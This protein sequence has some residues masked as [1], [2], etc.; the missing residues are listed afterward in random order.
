VAFYKK[1]IPMELHYLRLLRRW[2]WLFALA[3]IIASVSAFLIVRGQPTVYEAST[4]MIVGSAIDSPNPDLNT[5]RASG[6]LLQTYAEL[7]T[8]RPFLQAII[9]ELDLDVS[10]ND[11]MEMLT[12]TANEETQILT[13][14]AT[15]RDPETAVAVA[16][17]VANRLVAVSPSG[18]GEATDLTEEMLAQAAKLEQDV[19]AIEAQ[20]EELQAQLDV[21][22]DIDRQRLLLDQIAEE[23]NRLADTNRTLAQLYDT[24]LQPVTNKVTIIEPAVEAVPSDPQTMLIVLV[25]GLTGLILSLSAVFAME[26]FS[27]TIETADDLAQMDV[28]V[29]GTI[30][31]DPLLSAQR[32]QL[33]ARELPKS[34][35][36]EMYR[37][38]GT[39]VLVLAESDNSQSILL[40]STR[41]EDISGLAANLAVVL[42]QA[43][44]RVILVDADFHHSSVGNAF[45]A[46]SGL[47]LTEALSGPSDRIVLTPIE[48]VPGLSI[49]PTG[50]VTDDAFSLLASRKMVNLL[51]TLKQ[52]ADIIL[53]VAPP[54]SIVA[55]GLLLASYVDGAIPV[56]SS[57]KTRQADI[58]NVVA[59]LRSVGAEVIGIALQR[60]GRR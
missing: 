21:T 11:L 14:R 22:V 53:V 15:S 10:P 32:G 57:G 43:G 3:T 1:G 38:L 16:N 18:T 37:M 52:Q 44:P 48:G 28:P 40:T 29:L 56:A 2:L 30:M 54:L 50:Q 26:Y 23:R 41:R 20:I 33:T 17:A 49:L 35:A 27:N 7:P 13:A 36:A 51:N 8:T 12:I 55:E 24:L 6:Q 46:G 39:K 60:S 31:E 19:I 9:D 25:A 42:A 5:L 47:G 34:Q 59:N 58:Q 4:R 45:E